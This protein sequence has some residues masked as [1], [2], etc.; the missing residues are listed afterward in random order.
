M[1]FERE[2]VKEATI[3]LKTCRCGLPLETTTAS[4]LTHDTLP[5]MAPFCPKCARHVSKYV[6]D[7]P[8]GFQ[9]VGV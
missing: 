6:G 8:S 4:G 3:R 5:V 2:T 7:L 1:N 9:L